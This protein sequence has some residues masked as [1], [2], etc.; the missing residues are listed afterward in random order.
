MKKTLFIVLSL[1]LVILLSFIIGRKK[2]EKQPEA[3]KQAVVQSTQENIGENLFNE[4]CVMCHTDNKKMKD[5]KKTEDIMKTMRNPKLGMPTF[6]GK[7]I[8]NDAAEA[9]TK[10]IFFSILLKK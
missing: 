1:L 3:S 8:P 2:V 6:N 7:E 4:H 10:Y 5:I 9:I